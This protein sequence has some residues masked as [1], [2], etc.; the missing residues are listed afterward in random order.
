[1]VTADEVGDSNQLDIRCIVNGE[2][3]Q[4]SHTSDMKSKSWAR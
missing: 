1:M 4:Q 2:V 3:R